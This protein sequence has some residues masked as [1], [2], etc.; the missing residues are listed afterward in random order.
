MWGKIKKDKCDNC[1][2][3]GWNDDV[4]DF[5][6]PHCGF[7]KIETTDLGAGRAVYCEGCGCNYSDGCPTCP[8]EKQKPWVK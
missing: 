4:K 6:C 2:G 8:E 3:P 7:H 1:G 5:E